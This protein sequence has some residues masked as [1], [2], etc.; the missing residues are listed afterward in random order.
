MEIKQKRNPRIGKVIKSVVTAIYFTI[1]INRDWMIQCQYWA[2]IL[3]AFA[4]YHSTN[5]HYGQYSVKTITTSLSLSRN[6]Q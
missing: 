4:S 6:S 1:T 5:E 2:D 3:G